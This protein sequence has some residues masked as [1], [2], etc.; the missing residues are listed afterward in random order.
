MVK[1]LYSYLTY[2]HVLLP[3]TGCLTGIYWLITSMEFSWRLVLVVALLTVIGAGGFFAMATTYKRVYI[4]DNDLY[5]Y[6]LFSNKPSAIPLVQLRELR[7]SIDR[8]DFLFGIYTAT[9]IVE[10]GTYDVRF[11]KNKLI[12]SLDDYIFDRME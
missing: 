4:V 7:R 2:P 11:I 5:F 10:G 12:G 8:Y 9:F 3:S 1:R 6:S